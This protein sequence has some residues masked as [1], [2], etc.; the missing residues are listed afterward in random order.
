MFKS[1]KRMTVF[2]TREQRKAIKM[3]CAISGD[4]QSDFIKK[5]LVKGCQELGVVF[6]TGEVKK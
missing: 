3:A 5:Q 2:L 4:N 1:E 6:E